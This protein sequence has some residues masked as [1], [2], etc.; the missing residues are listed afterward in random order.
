MEI[1]KEVDIL[2]D[3]LV[4]VRHYYNQY[5]KLFM[6]GELRL[7]LL[8]KTAP[9]FFILL[10]GMLWDQM[11]IRLARLTDS[12]RKGS[13]ENLSMD[14]LSKLAEQNGWSFSDEMKELLKE[15]KDIVK[16]VRK[17]RNKT[18]AHRDLSTAMSEGAISSPE[19]AVSLDQINKALSILEK[20]M[21]LVYENLAQATQTWNL[22]QSHD[23]DEVIYYLK[24]A[25]I[26]KDLED[27][28]QDWLKHPT[29]WQNSKYRD[30]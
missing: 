16:S 29:L 26:Y 21:N 28:E 12:Y 14:I 2:R 23:V 11:I 19:L 5:K 22:I 30:A 24:R 18:I 10:Q 25:M 8:N 3:D 6:S 17:R 13:D 27:A 15:A 9:G 7:E 1:P 20:A 4:W